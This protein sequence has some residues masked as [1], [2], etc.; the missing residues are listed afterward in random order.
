MIP[1]HIAVEGLLDA[2]VAERIAR[3]NGF[4]PLPPNIKGGKGNLDKLL[5]AFNNA[6]KGSPW[7]V[8]RD[9]DRDFDCPGGLRARLI[10]SPQKWMCFRI[11]VRAVES[12]LLAD[13]ERFALF[14]KLRLTDIPDT[15]DN[16]LNPKSTLL[17]LITRSPSRTLRNALLPREGSGGR[18]GPLYSSAL[19]EFVRQQWRPEQAA[20]NSQS[21]RRCMLQLKGLSSLWGPYIQNASEK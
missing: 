8:L 21:L 1:I 17:K 3:D 19:S 6:A 20:K 5:L 9:L 10:P 2:V 11:P 15:P 18:E 12:W 13:R 4:D 7:F 16:L 14:A